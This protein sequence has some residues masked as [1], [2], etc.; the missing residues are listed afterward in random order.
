M[1]TNKI[2]TG[3]VALTATCLSMQA[4]DNSLV[5]NSS[6]E[7]TH[8]RVHSPGA[9]FLSDSISSAN[10]TTVDLYSKD[11]CGR[12][13][14]VPSNYMG[15]QASKSGS[16]Y[17]GIIAYYADDA[18]LFRTIPGYRKYSE[19]IQFAFR[20]PLVT[21]R[22]YSVSFSLSLSEESA[23]AVSGLGLYFS[24]TKVDVKNNSFL[25]IT[26]YFV[27]VDILTSTEWIPFTCT[28]VAS[29]GERYLTLG[30]F[31]KYMDTLKVIADNTN[32]SRKAYYYVDDVGV[33]PQP[34]KSQDITMVLDGSC[35]HLQ[36]LNFE[37]DKAVILASSYEELKTLSSFLKSYPHITVYIDGHTDKTGTDLHNKK[38][39][40]ERASAVKAHLEQNGIRTNRMKTRAYGESLPIDTQ[41]DS[42]LANRRVEIAICAA[43]ATPGEAQR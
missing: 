35:Y 12:Y 26:P 36:N 33:T 15:T 22:A 25:P 43:P 27:C 6:F 34:L 18:G 11:A 31:D 24:T 10:N 3:M 28:Y 32:N 41:N 16:N 4:Q 23:Y 9:Y 7:N 8:G 1:K 21:G 39:S 30:C 2:V 29:G 5:M 37:T 19:Y 13:Y 17:A 42:S 40:A 20:E 14:G 38:L